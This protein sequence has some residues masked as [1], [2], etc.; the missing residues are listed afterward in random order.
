MIIIILIF[1]IILFLNNN[2]KESF[3]GLTEQGKH[4]KCRACLH[5][6]RCRN[7]VLDKD[8]ALNKCIKS[9]ECDMSRKWIY[10]DISCQYPTFSNQYVYN[11]SKMTRESSE[12]ENEN[13]S[14]TQLNC[15]WCGLDCKGCNNDC[16]EDCKTQTKC[17]Y[18]ETQNN[19]SCSPKCSESD[20]ND[21]NKELC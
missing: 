13:I 15:L 9:E 1:C 18:E 8:T 17:T 10:D 5:Y 19:Q 16:L 3:T 7:I 20:F 21:L 2:F 6:E 4:N 12:I 14:E 11:S